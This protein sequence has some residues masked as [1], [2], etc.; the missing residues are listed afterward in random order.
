MATEE[1]EILPRFRLD[2]FKYFHRIYY[3][4][5]RLWRMGSDSCPEYLSCGQARGSL[6]H[7]I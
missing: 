3:T 1:L 6:M 7:V 2:Q 5:D 4:P